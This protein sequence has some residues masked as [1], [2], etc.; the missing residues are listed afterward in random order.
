MENNKNKYLILISIILLIEIINI[1]RFIST[2]HAFYY[3]SQNKIWA[4]NSAYR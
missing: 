1:I 2:M 4:Q 3:Y